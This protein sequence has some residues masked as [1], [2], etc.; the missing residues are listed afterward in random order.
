M[1][2]SALDFTLESDQYQ[3][4]P[5]RWGRPESNGPGPRAGPPDKTS[6]KFLDGY[7]DHHDFQLELQV[8]TL[9]ASGLPPAGLSLQSES[10]FAK[11]YHHDA[12]CHGTSKPP[13]VTVTQ[14]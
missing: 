8:W 1:T 14:Q 12:Q 13:T 5:I 6:S 11:M 2:L 10:R 7:H 3:T 4:S 9:V